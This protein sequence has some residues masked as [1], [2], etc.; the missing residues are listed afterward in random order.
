MPLCRDVEALGQVVDRL[1]AGRLE[2]L[3][4]AA[5]VRR[6]GGGRALAGGLLDVCRVV[7]ALAVH[8][9]VFAG[10][11]RHHELVRVRAA[12]DAS[13][14]L[15]GDGPQAAARK[16]PR[17]GVVHPLVTGVG[18]LV[19]GVEAVRVLHD[20]FLGA[21]EAEA[22]ADFVTELGLNLVKIDRQLAVRVELIG[23]E[24]GDDLLMRRAEHPLLTG[25]ILHVKKHVLR[26]LEPAA[27]GPDGGRLERR[28]EHLQ[29]P[30]AIHLLADDG[31]DF[32]ERPQAKR[33]ERVKPAGEF[34]HQ[35]GTQQQL[36]GN[37]LRLGGRLLQR[38]DKCLG[39]A[40]CKKWDSPVAWPALASEQ[41]KPGEV[42]PKRPPAT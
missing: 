40:H 18:R 33:Q 5:V 34:S 32:L 28:H 27:P 21:H 4:V 10:L 23:D 38:R 36:V 26:R 8:H 1:H 17:V 11:G 24:G 9:L 6:R 14:G 19:V 15:H 25:A 42:E 41:E 31:L 16:N 22:R 2:F 3:R 13:V 12:H 35:A 20:E 37:D 7:A 39:P 29:R 30:G